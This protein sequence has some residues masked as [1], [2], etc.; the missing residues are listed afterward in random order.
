[1]NQAIAVASDEQGHGFDL[2]SDDALKHKI[3]IYFNELIADLNDTLLIKHVP[4]IN[5]CRALPES[6]KTLYCGVMLVVED[7]DADA[8]DQGA[9]SYI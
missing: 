2:I 7:V 8:D 9:V 6:D 5:Y 3:Y 1:M 4:E